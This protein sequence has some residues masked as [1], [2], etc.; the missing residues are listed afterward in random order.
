MSAALINRRRNSRHNGVVSALMRARERFIKEQQAIQADKA[1][2]PRR[3]RDPAVVA[4]CKHAA[5][6]TAPGHG[7]RKLA[8]AAWDHD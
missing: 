5:W 1:A 7:I 2:F 3:Q 8:K 6:Q 4:G